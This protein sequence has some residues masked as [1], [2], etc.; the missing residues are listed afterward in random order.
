MIQLAGVVIA[1]TVNRQ[2]VRLAQVSPDGL[3]TVAGQAADRT[4]A[5]PLPFQLPDIVHVSP[6]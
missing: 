4:N 5:Q 6:P 2:S 3:A 1:W